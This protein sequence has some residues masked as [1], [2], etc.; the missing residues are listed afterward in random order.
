[1]QYIPK[2]F[3]SHMLRQKLNLRAVA[4]PLQSS[5]APPVADP[6]LAET[7]VLM[8]ETQLDSQPEV[9]SCEPLPGS[10]GGGEELDY[11]T[12]TNGK[13]DEVA[14]PNQQESPPNPEPNPPIE[15]VPEV[16]TQVVETTEVVEPEM[17]L[18]NSDE[19]TTRHE[20]FVERDWLQENF[21]AKGKGKGKGKGNAKAKAA[22][23][24]KQAQAK[25]KAEKAKAATLRKAKAN[26]KAEKTEEQ[27]ASAGAQGDPEVPAPEVKKRRKASSKS[28]RAIRDDGA[29]DADANKG[30]ASGDVTSKPKAPQDTEET[31]ETFARRYRPVTKSAGQRWDGMKAVFNADVGPKFH[32]PA[33]LED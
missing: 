6:A 3:T 32:R 31:K 26:A 20:Q 14:S 29:D 12:V 2:T 22:E 10:V 17:D 23:Q 27:V 9:E 18:F 28:K 25:A 24:V 15:E 7:L 11:P 33:S 5:P 21:P 19:L 13:S 30:D 1:M 8:P 16:E 4:R